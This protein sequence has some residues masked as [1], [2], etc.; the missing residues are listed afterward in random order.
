ML[1][2]RCGEELRFPRGLVHAVRSAA[3]ILSIYD[4]DR[5]IAIRR[6]TGY[7]PELGI[8]RCIHV[9]LSHPMFLGCTIA[10][11]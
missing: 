1:L 11:S 9:Q 3:K 4:G 5:G 7:N 8:E 2:L 6:P 10:G